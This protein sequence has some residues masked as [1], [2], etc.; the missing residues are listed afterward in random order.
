M[1]WEHEK[2]RNGPFVGLAKVSIDL[3]DLETCRRSWKHRLRV[4]I[5]VHRLRLKLIKIV[6][7]IVTFMANGPYE[8]K[9]EKIS[10]LGRRRKDSGPWTQ[11]VADSMMI[12]RNEFRSYY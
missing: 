11:A 4:D 7:K 5:R 10:F 9:S 8:P 1:N 3:T 6:I 2:P 12:L